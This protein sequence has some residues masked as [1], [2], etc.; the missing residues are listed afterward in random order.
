[1]SGWARNLAWA[2]AVALAFFAFHRL[3]PDVELGALN[4]LSLMVFPS[5]SFGPWGVLI[6]QLVFAVLAWLVCVRFTRFDL[7][8]WV[9]FANFLLMFAGHK[10]WEKYHLALIA[11]LWYLRS[12]SDLTSP[13]TLWNLAPRKKREAHR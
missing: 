13:V 4:R 9:L 2:G 11:S 12:L 5:E 8:W 10:G 1:M 7:I 6:R 3:S